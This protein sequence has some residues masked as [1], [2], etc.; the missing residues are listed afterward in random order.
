MNSSD[1]FSFHR[2]FKKNHDTA[3][4][5]SLYM[6]KYVRNTLIKFRFG[7]SNIAM[8]ALRYNIHTSEDTI[9]PLCKEAVENE[10]HFSLCCTALDD[11]RERYIPDNISRQPCAFRL[12][13]LLSSEN[14]NIIKN[15]TLFCI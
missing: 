13:L 10:V 6:N 14:K 4:Y 2:N 7:I 9:C 5:F 11:I 1:R 3:V 15:V 8:H 12:A